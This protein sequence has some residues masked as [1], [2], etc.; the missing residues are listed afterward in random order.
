MSGSTVFSS[1]YDQ[2]KNVREYHRKFPAQPVTENQ[3]QVLLTEVLESAPD[4]GFTGEESEGR[5]VDMHELHEAYLNVKGVERVDYCSYLKQCTDIGAIPKAS[6]LTNGYTRYIKSLRE[7]W[8]SFL[9]RTQPLMPLSKLLE[10]AEADFDGRW[11]RGEVAR[12]QTGPAVATSAPLDL[13][14][15]A[16]AAELEAIGMEPLKAELIRLGLKAG[17][18]LSQRAER[19]FLTKSTPLDQMPKQ[20]RSKPS[21]QTRAANGS[22]ANGDGNADSTGG[23]VG[24]A[25]GACALALLEEQVSRLGQLLTDTLEETASMIEKKQARTYDEIERDLALA[26]EEDAQ[27]EEEEE[28]EEEKPIYN[29]LN[30]PLGWD[31]KPIPYW[32]YKLHGLNLEFKCEICGNYSYWGP[33]PFE[34]HFQE[35][36]HSY[37]MKC[38]GIPNTRP[39]QGI[40]LIEDAYTLWAKLKAEAGTTTFDAEMD[41]EYED[42]QGN[43]MNR[44]VYTDLARQGLLD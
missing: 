4:K 11:A 30:L 15:Y 43:V 2:L 25:S 18:S 42:R 9:Q 17:G 23:G 21:A 34:R 37:G 7:Y 6:A 38:L 32:L 14:G 36:R 12:W 28:E 33:R 26:E 40:T 22:S 31:G 41:E 44:K 1:F 35:W 10:A 13:G 5:Y 39:F 27:P 24:G 20:H 16:S 8:L 3:E 29:P 19:L